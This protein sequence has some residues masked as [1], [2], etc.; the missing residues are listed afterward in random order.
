MPRYRQNTFIHAHVV[1]NEK[2]AA[3]GKTRELPRA[4]WFV[5]ISFL[6]LLTASVEAQTPTITSLSEISDPSGNYQITQDID[7]T[8]FTNSISTFSGTL[9]AAISPVTHM[10]YRI[11]NLS[12]PLFTTLTGTVCNL[13]IDNVAISGTG[14]TGA[15][16]CTANG[17]S[18]MWASS[19]EQ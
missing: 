9:E 1:I 6:F 5:F 7:A 10:P 18:I 16:A 2:I 4:L 13:A 14:N 12:V 15:I 8:S 19:A 17:A 3:K 11:K